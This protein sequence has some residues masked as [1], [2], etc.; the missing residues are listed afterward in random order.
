MKPL[1]YINNFRG[2]KNT[3]LQLERVNFFVGEN[4]TGKTS[5]LKLVKILSE[6]EFWFKTDSDHFRKEFGYFSEITTEK[7]FEIGLFSLIPQ[8]FIHL[9]FVDSH[10][11]AK[12]K[13]IRQIDSNINMFI[14]LT[15]KGAEYKFKKGNYGDYFKDK[16]LENFKEWIESDNLIDE[17]KNINKT[18]KAV[19]LP[20]ILQ[21]HLVISK[22]LEEESKSFDV[23]SLVGQL[24]WLAPIRT[25]PK[26]TYDDYELNFSPE[27]THVPY[28][29]KKQLSNKRTKQ[30][31][32]FEEILNR[33]G[34][35]S[36]LF[37]K[38]TVSQYSKSNLSPFEINVVLNGKAL[39]IINVGYGVS[40]ILPLI[41]ETVI[42]SDDSWLAIQQPEI[43]LH[44]KGQAAFGDLL[45]KSALNDGKGFIVETHSDYTID[46]YRL[47]LSR[48][49]SEESQIERDRIESQVVFFNRTKEGNNLSV[50][51]INPNGSYSED[52]PR[53]FKE[54]FIREEL[55]LLQ[56]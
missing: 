19:N 31:K 39:K 1:L 41:V 14:C 37:E 16:Q 46:R 21:I 55:A 53:E 30:S 45:F 48:H 7:S 25:E 44:P 17:K 13:E 35:D 42:R 12:L 50:I 47:K 27:G 34:E 5:I 18:L 4:S 8:K 11:F 38:I 23:P 36:G 32:K 49:S 56:I 33:F 15:I 9:K 22:H 6:T 28:I 54:F 40:Q 51:S 26:R 52:Q 24:A 3:F 2:F 10:G 29:L 43:H 20:L